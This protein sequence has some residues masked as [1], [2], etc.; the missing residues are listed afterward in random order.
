MSEQLQ[1]RRGTSVQ[2]AAFTGAQ[3]ELVVDTTNNRLVVQDGV[4]AGGFAAAKLAEI[5]ALS[6]RS[7]ADATTTI[8]PSDRM[9][10]FS[11]LTASRT[12]TL[13]AASAFPTGA[14]LTVIDESGSCSAANAIV[15][16][17]AG[18]DLVDGA[19][20]ASLS[21]AYGAIAF[22]SNGA[23]AWTIVNSIPN[24]QMA[25]LGI[26]AAP[27]PSNPLTVRAST[28][29][30][31][32]AS[33][34]FNV[35]VNKTAPGNTASFL[36]QD[37]FSGR[38]Q[39]GLC[40][41]DNF[42]FKVSSNGSTFVNAI[43]IEAT[44]GALTFSN[45]RTPVA[46]AAYTALVTDR[47]IAFTAITAARVVSLPPAASFP[48]GHHL[49]I[50]DESGACS[51]TNIITMARNGADTINGAASA[52]IASAFGFVALES[53]G[54]SAWTVVDQSTLSMAQ[55]ASNAVAITGGAVNATPVG[56]T[57]P[58]TG[59]FTTL[60]MTGAAALAAG[61]SGAAPLKF[62]VG[63][64]QTVAAAGAMEYDG[65]AFYG[66]VAAAARGA[67]KVQ[68]VAILASAYTLTSQTAAQKL[69]NST[70]AG[71]VTLAVGT[72][73]FECF[74]S[75]TALSASSGSFGFALGG[76]ATFTQAWQSEAVQAAGLATATA[77]VKTYNVAANLALTIA[78]TSTTGYALIKGVIRVTTA[79]TVIPQV[80]LTV[81]AAAIVGANSYFSI[82]PLG[83]SALTS[84]GN[85]S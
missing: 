21:A 46:D 18:T 84:L 25:L 23:G 7:V 72:Y 19:A 57:T 10:A 41:N 45:L 35:V 59:S 40:G 4:T 20:S 3:G 42:S 39:I 13:C 68:Q 17:R 47:L 62:T 27:D 83:S 58:S 61:T 75:L 74:F 49:S 44:T 38:A 8:L 53:N 9:V 1:L 37:A 56:S 64:N 33:A 66:S 67:I 52:V 50:I 34:G 14:T 11:S 22:E 78:S 85:W 48:A 54:A 36:F 69:L 77:A 6:R 30:F 60:S 65:A 43:V 73:Q 15:I 82:A 29:L 80:S 26:G 81:A 31:N 24:Q 28:A 55:Q 76:A 5:P 63:V 70:P 51:G 16:N 79:G 12:I 2:V 32:A 71:A